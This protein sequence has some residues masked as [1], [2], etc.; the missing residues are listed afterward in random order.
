MKNTPIKYEKLAD[1]FRTLG[2]PVRVAIIDMLCGCSPN[3]LT[4]K[5]IYENLG[6]DQPSASR[7]LN[8]MRRSGVLQR[9]KETG[10][11]FYCLCIDDPYVECL[12]K[13]FEKSF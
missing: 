13:C 6:I 10:N 9:I 7:H 5:N 8:I 11:T 2:H 4:V 3:R 12:K 1:K